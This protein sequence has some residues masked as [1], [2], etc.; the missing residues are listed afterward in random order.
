[1]PKRKLV[2]EVASGSGGKVRIDGEFINNLTGDTKDELEGILELG[3]TLLDITKGLKLTTSKKNDEEADLFKYTIMMYIR[4][5]AIDNTV[6]FLEI[7]SE[8]LKDEIIDTLFQHLKYKLP[9]DEKLNKRKRK[10]GS[11]STREYFGMDEEFYWLNLA[12]DHAYIYIGESDGKR[13][14]NNFTNAIDFIYRSDPENKP[15][16]CSIM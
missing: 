4:R 5:S 2:T 9:G 12:D 13:Y 3:P 6:Q 8:L 10:D 1:M 14:K 15:S 7:E 11:F 16:L